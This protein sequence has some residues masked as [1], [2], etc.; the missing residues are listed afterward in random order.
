MNGP[1]DDFDGKPEEI[2]VVKLF[3]VE[4]GEKSDD[5]C[6]VDPCEND[7]TCK[8]TWNDYECSCSEGWKGRNCTEKEFCFWRP[9][10]EQSICQS[11]ADGHECVSN[12][13]FNG[14]D[15]TLLAKPI[16]TGNIE[17]ATD[18]KVKFRSRSSGGTLLQ[19]LGNDNDQFIR[20]VLEDNKIKIDLP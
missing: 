9:C 17:N 20:L 15:S 7:G 14:V 8:V 3:E 12:A 10:P 1:L 13:T 19:L 18:I 11:L 16:L 4:K 6:R 2:G 5:S